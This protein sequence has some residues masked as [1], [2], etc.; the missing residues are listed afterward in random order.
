MAAAAWT[1]PSTKTR[2]TP[3]SSAAAR[4]AGAGSGVQS[5]ISSTP[6]TRAATAAIRTDEGYGAR[7]P[8][9]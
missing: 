6:A 2:S 3:A 9:T 7:P 8:G 1:G 5:T 4:T